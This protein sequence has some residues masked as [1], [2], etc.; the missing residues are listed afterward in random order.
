MDSDH[1]CYDSDSSVSSVDSQATVAFRPW[2]GKAGKIDRPTEG[3]IGNSSTTSCTSA[4]STVSALDDKEK[5]DTGEVEP[6]AELG[7]SLDG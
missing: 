3:R 5:V 7:L 6:K 2:L 4:S 1:D